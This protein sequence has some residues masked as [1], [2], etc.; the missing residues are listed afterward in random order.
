MAT[1]RQNLRKTNKT[2]T[3]QNLCGVY[4]IDSNISLNKTLFLMPLFKHFGCYG[5]LK[6]TL[7]YNGK[8]ENYDLI[9]DILAKVSQKGLMSGLPPNISF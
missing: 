9:V 8:S 2:S 7:T 4:R 6:F 1:K 3:P 5:N